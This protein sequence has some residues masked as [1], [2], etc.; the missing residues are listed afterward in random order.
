M[1]LEPF[2][3][4]KGILI[5][6]NIPITTYTRR[7]NRPGRGQKE[8]HGSGIHF[9]PN[10]PT[11]TIHGQ[12]GSHDFHTGN[13]FNLIFSTVWIPGDR[14]PLVTLWWPLGQPAGDPLVNRLVTPGDSLVTP[15]ELSGD[16][17]WTP[18][19]PEFYCILF[20]VWNHFN[21]AYKIFKII[22]KII[23]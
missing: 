5:S 22:F 12:C 7:N 18:W 13:Y 9:F 17:W 21:F 19:W 4:N 10:N 3:K 20:I 1:S 23:D 15:G 14:E 8:T 11:V 6:N 16:P 2:R